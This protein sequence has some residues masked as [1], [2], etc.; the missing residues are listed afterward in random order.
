MVQAF[1]FAG[2]MDTDS[3]DE[4]I[5]SINHRE[6]WN[7]QWKGTQPNLRAENTPGTREKTNPFL[8][9]DGN[10]LTIA[11]FYDSVKKR[12]F[13]F[14]RRGDGKN[15]IYM[16]DT[17]N[18]FFARLVEQGFNANN[19]VLAFTQ[20]V[21]SNINII[22]GDS[23][24]GDILYW[25][26]GDG[27]PKKVNIDR[28]ISGG[29]GNIQKSYLEVDKQPA[30]IPP[31]VVYEND[32][33]N[34][35]NNCRKRLFRFKIRWVFDDHDKSVTSSQS[36]MPLP[37]DAFDQPTDSDPT[38]NCRIAIVYQT[39][40][41]NVKKIEILASNSLGVTMAD[42]YLVASLDKSVVGLPDNDVATFLFYN[43]QAYT[44]IDV[45]ESD[46]LFDYVP[47]SC[48]TQCVL[49]GNVLSYGNITEGYANLTNFSDGTST[50]NISSTETVYASGVY[51]AK[52]VAN[53][54][55]ASG[56]G[57]GTIHIVL[58]GII[59]SPSFQLDTYTIYMTDG[60]T[61]T[62]TAVLNDD[63][64][65]I[66]NGLRSDAISKGYTINSVG[67][68]DLY[69][70][71]SNI[72][73]A[74]ALIIPAG[75]TLNNI[76]NTSYNAYDWNSKYAFGQVYFDAKG[77][78]NGAVYTDG[79][80]IQTVAYT[81]DDFPNDQPKLVASIYHQP[82]SWAQY[83]Q[84]VRAKNLSKDLKLQWI[85]DRTFK[86]TVAVSGLTRYA[87]LSIESVNTFVTANPGSPLGYSFTTGDRITFMKR[88][89]S[90]GTTAN[91]YGHTK[92]FEIIG[93]VTNP[94]VN[95]DVKT[96]Q[97]V[98]IILP[99]TDGTFDFGTTGFDNYFIEL[100]TPAQPVANN[101]NLYYE[102]GERYAVINP[103]TSNRAHQG[104]TQNQVW[105]SQPA[106][107]EFIK[108]DYYTRLR[109]IQTG[110]AYSFNI[111][112]GG[113]G[114]NIDTILIG[115]NFN[116][117]TYT[118][119]GITPQSVPYVPLTGSFNPGGDSRH[120]LTSTPNTTFHVKGTITLTF[121]NNT[122]GD[123]WHIYHVDKFNNNY[124]VVAP[125]NCPDPGTF[126]FSVDT[127]I[128]I[129]NNWIFLI[130]ASTV[131][132]ARTITFSASNLTY[133]I[134]H[135]ID[136]RCIDPNFSDYFA[137]AV[138]SNG[139]AF[140]YDENAN[141]V[142]Y[143][144]M[145]RW[146]LAY[147]TDTN[148][149]QTCRFYATNFDTLMRDYGALRRMM[150]W[151]KVLTLFQDRKVGQVG[152][153]KKFITDTAGNQ[154]L[155]TTTDIITSNNVQYYAGEFGVG[156]QGDSVVQSGFV[157][158]FVDPVRG[159]QLRLSRDGITDLSELYKTQ[160]W[161]AAN[162]TKY[163]NAYNYTYGGNARITGTWNVRKD[164]V[165]EWL[166]CLQE[167][168]LGMETLASQTI[169][170]NES[171]NAF[172]SFFNFSP[173]C[174]VCAENTL[175]SWSNGKMYIHDNTSAYNT[176]Y[177]QYFDST[178]TRVF[179]HALIQKKSWMSLTEI[180]NSIWD[181]PVIY[182]N[183]FSYGI[184]PQQSN[185]ITQDFADIE[186]T[187]SASFLGDQNSIGGLYGDVLKGNFIVIKFRAPNAT[188][189]KT[190]TAINLYYIDS[191]FTNV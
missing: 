145:Y 169:S 6:A 100:Y 139:R 75:A 36:E 121:T 177:G 149:N 47:Q 82:P 92:D 79:F 85:T 29:Y 50:S 62:Y 61:I 147:Q 128:T 72:S 171:R 187:Y 28:A 22:Y 39:G 56:F 41:A 160:T 154:Q 142:N 7:I 191:P 4:V 10:N 148:I 105:L 152:I 64:S 34:T 70:T 162:I 91:L 46:Q 146:S 24:Q 16:Y 189:L 120:F 13:F 109:G 170:F 124:E 42:F 161:A 168:A 158:Y 108:G 27:T 23:T 175:Y 133:T 97:F 122:A 99:A 115:M 176:F 9:N 8:I 172:E 126:T 164:N 33:S 114:N 129:N 167:G 137:S 21:I 26:D 144:T 69:V 125:F 110:N 55:G 38:K 52:L 60:S 88:Y 77:R 53:Q 17:V 123:S 86:D 131:S 14:N 135:V 111:L 182:T 127:Y 40:P 90:D 58:R 185:L 5:P 65:A 76:L 89:N 66:I 130:A 190:L 181:C 119:A 180:G 15:A 118:V 63:A 157:Y 48:V 68:N 49:N 104:M 1:P 184:T 30:D 159:K 83:W 51:F 113:T 151:D 174:I 19:D 96:G 163:L 103:G 11:R 93:S 186:S 57:T 78:T 37:F 155:I 74:R 178:V 102:Y 25:V 165:G 2:I 156:N 71:K 20:N 143:P 73:L 153:Y 54:G 107:F 18:V 31:Y 101:L 179:N 84:W 140:A 188:T 183:Y 94:T 44:N 80:S 132:H 134:D 117:S 95:G 173:D 112:Q 141:Q 136:Q 45:T 106:L 116:G 166:C 59:S 150:V 3:P 43:N 87:Y 98:K 35:V 67:S 81:E 32:A 138:N 12:I